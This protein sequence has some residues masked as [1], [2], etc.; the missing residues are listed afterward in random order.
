[1]KRAVGISIRLQKVS[2]TG[3]VEGSVPS[4]M[5]EEMSKAQPLE[6]MMVIHL[7]RLGTSGL[8]EGAVG[9]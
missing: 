4:R 3:V 2:D 1:M 7:D 9:E 5:K 8:K 6:K